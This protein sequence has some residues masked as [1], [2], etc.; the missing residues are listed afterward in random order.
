MAEP[1][2]RQRAEDGTKIADV[3]ISGLSVQYDSSRAETLALSD[4][5]LRVLPSEF[6]CLIGGPSGCGKTTL[7]NVVAGFVPP[8]AGEVSIRGNPVQ[9]RAVER[10][11]VFQEYALFPWRNAWRN[12]ASAWRPSVCPGTSCA[13][14]LTSISGS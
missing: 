10:G 6:I 4:V 13:S 14:G 3:T 9:S 5:E 12:V 7:L 11:M 8:T 2:V 1:D